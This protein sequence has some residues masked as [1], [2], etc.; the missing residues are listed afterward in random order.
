M[1][2]FFP[3][4]DIEK[5]L[6]CLD[7]QRLGK[8]RVEAKQILNILYGRTDSKSWSN[9][10]ATRMF[11]GYGDFLKLY[12]NK[13]CDAWTARGYVNN[14]EREFYHNIYT[15]EKPAWL[16]NYEFHLSHRSNLLRK[17]IDDSNGIGAGGKPK[18]KSTELLDRLE[19]HGIIVEQTPSDLPYIWPC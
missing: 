4:P 15:I 19:K 9:H 11:E 1:Q 14:M 16:G 3:F 17:A 8:Q 5:S 2:V 10:P 6:D 13:C 7:R 12:F 18:K